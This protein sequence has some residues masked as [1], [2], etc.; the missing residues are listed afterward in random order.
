M[1]KKLLL[2]LSIVG[3]IVVA[4]IVTAVLVFTRGSNTNPNEPESVAAQPGD[5]L[6]PDKTPVYGACTVLSQ[7]D[8]TSAL[9]ASTVAN[10]VNSGIVATNYESANICSY[11]YTVGETSGTFRV[12]VYLYTANPDRQS[13]EAFDLSWRNI[14]PIP[15]PEYT[16]QYPANYKAFENG[17]NKDYTVQI[18]TGNRN[19]RFVASRPTSVTSPD[20]ES[21]IKSLLTLASK[22]NYATGANDDIPPAPEV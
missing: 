10:G 2:I 22:A 5:V 16:L 7:A 19:Y 17:E 20:E 15:Y 9:G 8:M 3:V 1:S 11:K 4:G 14:S 18:S 6:S 12:E 21:V 13:T